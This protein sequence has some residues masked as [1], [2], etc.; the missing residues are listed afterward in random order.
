[1]IPL[2][3]SNPTRSTPVLT[4]LIIAAN[5]LVYLFQASLDPESEKLFIERFGLIPAMVAQEHYVGSLITPFTSMFMHGGLMH[6]LLNM[7]SL[8]IFGDNVEDTLGKPRFLVFY[9]ASGLGAAAAQVYVDPSSTI[10]M[11]GASGAIAGVLAAYLRLFPH[12]R[13]LTLIP[14]FIFFFTREIPA[15]VFIVFWFV[16]QV[17]SGV[18]SLSVAGNPATGG[19]AFFAHIGGFLM[20]LLVVRALTPARNGTRGF[21][22]PEQ[23]RY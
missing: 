3:D 21:R 20:G 6:L 11:V 15:V 14:L 19:V 22:R 1:V 8:F 4:Y 18:G 16:M 23:Y 10:P 2:R 12:A 17:L 13:V 5:T 9:L 7:W